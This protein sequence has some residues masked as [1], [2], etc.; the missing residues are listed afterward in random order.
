MNMKIKIFSSEGM[1][2]ETEAESVRLN[3]CDGSIGIKKGC[4]DMLIALKQGMM[5]W[6]CGTDE[7]TV[8]L[9]DGFAHVHNDNINIFAKRI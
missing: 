9:S 3:A 1:S 2:F 4:A 7:N 5:Y 6:R 8:M